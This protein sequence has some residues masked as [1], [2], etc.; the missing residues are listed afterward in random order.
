MF[1]PHLLANFIYRNPRT[2]SVATYLKVNLLTGRV[3]YGAVSSCRVALQYIGVM[4]SSNRLPWT[5]YQQLLA[6]SSGA[7]KGDCVIW[8]TVIHT[9]A[10]C[11]ST[12]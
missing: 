6:M 4:V 2:S 9:V 3:R 7:S 12:C 11:R 5:M 1:M 8:R 10:L